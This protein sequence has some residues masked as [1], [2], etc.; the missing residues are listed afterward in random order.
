MQFLAQNRENT[1]MFL[2]YIDGIPFAG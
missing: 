2:A 1:R